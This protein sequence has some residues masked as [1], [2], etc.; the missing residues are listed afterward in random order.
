LQKNRRKRL[1][2][3]TGFAARLHKL[4]K[5]WLAFHI[6]RNHPVVQKIIQAQSR[7]H[8][9]L[10]RQRKLTR[11]VRAFRGGGQIPL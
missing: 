5:K 1:V 9:G 10:A 8:H 4:L 2:P 3:P 7:L 6:F 11:G